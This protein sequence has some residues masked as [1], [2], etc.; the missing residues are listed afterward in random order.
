MRKKIGKLAVHVSVSNECE[1]EVGKAGSEQSVRSLAQ[2]Q[3]ANI[4]AV[5]QIR[6]WLLLSMSIKIGHLLIII[7]FNTVRYQ[8]KVSQTK[9]RIHSDIS[10]VHGNGTGEV[11]QVIL[12]QWK[13]Q[14][15]YSTEYKTSY[16][17]QLSYLRSTI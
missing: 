16:F 2:A 17:S 3:Q 11:V 9:P 6:P 15:P 12:R 10:T 14:I 13:I 8:L 4:E 7:S 5:P 1:K